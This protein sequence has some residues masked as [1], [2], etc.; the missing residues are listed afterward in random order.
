MT[1][2]VCFIVCA[3]VCVRYVCGLYSHLSL[4][5]VC[6]ASDCELLQGAAIARRLVNNEHLEHKRVENVSDHTHKSVSLWMQ[7]ARILGSFSRLCLAYFPKMP[8]IKE[9]C[10]VATCDRKMTYL[11]DLF[12]INSERLYI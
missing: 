12:Y 3:R 5:G 2:R 10:P 7:G 8:F 9:S 4:R 11:P 6:G 1:T